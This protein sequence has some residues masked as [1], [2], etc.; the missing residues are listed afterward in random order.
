MNHTNEN[1]AQTV[2]YYYVFIFSK[3]K[4]ILNV[5]IE[6]HLLNKGACNLLTGGN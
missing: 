1:I 2:L 6:N 4:A 5:T 3:F